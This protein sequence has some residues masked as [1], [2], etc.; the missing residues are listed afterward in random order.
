VENLSNK[1]KTCATIRKND[2]FSVLLTS[3]GTTSHNLEDSILNGLI[4]EQ[5]IESSYEDYG[6][7]LQTIIDE[8]DWEMTD[9]L[10]VIFPDKQL[11][12]E[13]L[14]LFKGVQVWGCGSEKPCPECGC[15]MDPFGDG[16]G[17]L[18][19]TNWECENPNCDYRETEEP[20]WD[21]MPGGIDFDNH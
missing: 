17:T 7:N 3:I 6:K 20:D 8:N 19:W 13:I 1:H 14:E 2:S 4:N 15:E 21:V 12:S 11:N 5:L 10:N 16:I 9:F 18:Q